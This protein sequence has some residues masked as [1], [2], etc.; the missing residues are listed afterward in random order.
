MHSSCCSASCLCLIWFDHSCYHWCGHHLAL[1]DLKLCS[2]LNDKVLYSWG[3]HNKDITR[4]VILI[5]SCIFESLDSATKKALMVI[6]LLS[7]FISLSV[8]LY[9]PDFGLMIRCLNCSISKPFELQASSWK[10]WWFCWQDAADNCVSIEFIFLEQNSSHLADTL[11]SIN[12]FLKQIGDLENCA[13]Q[14]YIPG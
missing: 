3:G 9:S 12:K 8:L 2:I 14:N 11:G 4:K 13:F 7:A 6:H 10:K 1:A 5:S